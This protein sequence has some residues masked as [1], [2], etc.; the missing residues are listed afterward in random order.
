MPTETLQEKT[1]LLEAHGKNEAFDNFSFCEDKLA[2]NIRAT[3]MLT[4]GAS[5]GEM[6]NS[7]MEFED[8]GPRFGITEI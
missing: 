7:F 3:A 8:S 6:G 5:I 2:D 1:L 4:S